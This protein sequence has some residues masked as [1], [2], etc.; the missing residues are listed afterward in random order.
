MIASRGTVE[1]VPLCLWLGGV[2]RVYPGF[3]AAEDRIDIGETISLEDAGRT[4]R[5][6]FG[7]SGAHRD[8]PTVFGKLI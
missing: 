8:Y 5:A 4:G 6:V 2:T 3:K 1:Q 7:R